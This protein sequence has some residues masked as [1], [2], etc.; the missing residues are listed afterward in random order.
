MSIYIDYIECSQAIGNI[1]LETY[2]TGTQIYPPKNHSHWKDR[3]KKRI[4][5]QIIYM[6]S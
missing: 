6:V 3:G 5:L 4:R 2:I 1:V